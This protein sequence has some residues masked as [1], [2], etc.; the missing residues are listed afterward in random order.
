MNSHMSKTA[1]SLSW[2]PSIQTGCN[3]LCYKRQQIDRKQWPTCDMANDT[4]LTLSEYSIDGLFSMAFPTL[5][6]TSATDIS[7]H[8]NHKIHLHEWV[9]HLIHYQ[10]LHFAF[11]PHFQFF[12]LN[13]IFHH[14]SMQ[15]RKFLFSHNISH[16]NMTIGQLKLLKTRL[17]GPLSDRAPRRLQWREWD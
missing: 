17:K 14:R 11:H 7:L 15:C 6:P 8:H 9:K 1:S 12:A 4:C 16:H 10:D 2:S 13:I 3:H 5:F